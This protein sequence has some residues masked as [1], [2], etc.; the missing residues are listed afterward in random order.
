MIIIEG[1]TKFQKCSYI[2]LHFLQIS[3]DLSEQ[4]LKFQHIVVF[5]HVKSFNGSDIIKDPISL[6]K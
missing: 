5:E 2:V 4:R 1:P 6:T 3:R